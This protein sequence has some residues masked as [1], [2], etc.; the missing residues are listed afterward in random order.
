MGQY[1]RVPAGM[2]KLRFLISLS[3]E[4][5]PYQR[6]LAAVA[7]QTARRLG[8]EVQT[9]YAANDPITQS[10]QL[11]KAIQ[12][13]EDRRPDGILCS[14]VGTNMV[15]VARLAASRGIGWVLLNRD[16]D[17]IVDLRKTCSAPVFCVGMDQEEIGRIQ[18][19]QFGALLPSGG[20]V[21]CILG[22]NNSIAQR[23]LSGTHSTKPANVEIRT[24]PGNWTEES[25][26]KSAQR[27][28]AVK[29]LGNFAPGAGRR[30]K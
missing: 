7:Q 29:H 9:V 24:L 21:L 3:M 28:A 11:L 16:D 4:E 27:L 12:S 19:L 14:P 10:D 8:I 1:R 13:P 22:P 15:Q 6:L 30:T 26:H 5:S 17:Y 2:K 18:G 20:L 25:G 23:R